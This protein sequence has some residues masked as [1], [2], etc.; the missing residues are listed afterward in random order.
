VE[1]STKNFAQLLAGA[2]RAV[3]LTQ[4]ELAD[5]VNVALRTVQN[6]ESLNHEKSTEPRGKD[7]RKL[8]EVLRVPISYFQGGGSVET[9]SS[10]PPPIHEP[11]EIYGVERQFR[12]TT[13]S[14]DAAAIIDHFFEF[15]NR[16]GDHPARLQIVKNE[17]VQHFP[18]D[19][20]DP[21]PAPTGG[22]P[23]PASGLS[24]KE[25]ERRQSLA[26]SGASKALT[27]SPTQPRK[28]EAGEPNDRTGQP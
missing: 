16:C 23:A 1:T 25:S 24:S 8:C 27:E 22:Q 5:S 21:K 20:W 28:S 9:F 14:K 13:K 4:Q 18:L 2:R 26:A 6:W 10:D 12:F 11:R 3:G 19:R 17:L 15:M 7:L